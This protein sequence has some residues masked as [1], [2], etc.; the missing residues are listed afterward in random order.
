MSRI[1]VFGEALVDLV[2]QGGP[3]FRAVPGGGPANIAIG[4]ARLGVD[5]TLVTGL[6]EDAFGSLV[7]SHVTASGV[8]L[9]N[10]PSA[11]TGMA[12][13]TLADGVPAYDFALSWQ[14]A[15]PAVPPGTVA[16]HTGSLTA[17]LAPA[18]TEKAMAAAAPTATVC[19]DPNIRPVPSSVREVEQRRVARQV[20]LSD[21]VKAS[22]ED[23]AWL[24]PGE[25]PETI[26]RDWLESGPSVVV[27]TRGPRGCT[28]VTRSVLI[29]VPAPQ[30]TVADTVGAGDAFMAGLLAG[31]DTAGLL[32]AAKRDELGQLRAWTLKELLTVA[33]AAAAITCTRIGADPPTAA[34]LKR[35]LR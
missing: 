27:V 12:I 31:L 17:T 2:G 26:A 8:R 30:V 5:V 11:F 13:V 14:A 4:L 34:E 18:E 6:G 29:D 33:N 16:L 20:A 22:D 24:R 3:L 19:Y 1:T 15:V 10:Q 35:F 32:G 28:A 25:D 21:V 23:L 9:D 7:T